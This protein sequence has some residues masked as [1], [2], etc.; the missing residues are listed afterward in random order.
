MEATATSSLGARL[1]RITTRFSGLWLEPATKTVR[2]IRP[3]RS[4][5]MTLSV[6]QQMQ[7]SVR[8]HLL[9]ALA[10]AMLPCGGCISCS[11]F[12]GGSH[13]IIATETV[14]IQ[15]L[16]EQQTMLLSA[17]PPPLRIAKEL[18]AELCTSVGFG[19][20]KA[21]N[22]CSV[23]DAGHLSCEYACLALQYELGARAFAIPELGLLPGPLA[24]RLFHATQELL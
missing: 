12:R 22:G 3:R 19:K 13:L 11:G 9:F 21:L 6:F 17:A 1:L 20:T 5:R 7:S 4:N 15:S 14:P 18:C 8:R 23:I 10:G 2:S 24:Q 16:S